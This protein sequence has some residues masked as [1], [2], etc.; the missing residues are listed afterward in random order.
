MGGRRERRAPSSAG[1]GEG[2]TERRMRALE[3]PLDVRR[4]AGP[5]PRLE[6][7]NPIRGTHYTVHLPTYPD[8]DGAMCTCADFA[9]RGLGTCKHIEAAR[10]WLD[11][12]P[13]ERS[14]PA[15]PTEA[16]RTAAAEG[17]W[18]RVDRR[19]ASIASG[20]R[21]SPAA[22]LREPGIELTRPERKEEK[23]GVGDRGRGAPG[24]RPV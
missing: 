6:V 18:R 8:P 22:R 21:R 1:D 16:E 11:E 13:E 9:R 14:D 19:R 12:R 15:G 7:R 20:P 2:V 24:T 10:R 23:E 17:L 3:E 4:L 5:Y